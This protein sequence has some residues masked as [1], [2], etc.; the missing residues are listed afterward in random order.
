MSKFL[1]YLLF[2]VIGT[3][4]A[5]VLSFNY[6]EVFF[7]PFGYLTYGLLYIFFIEFLITKQ[8]KDWRVVYFLGILVGFI[9]E[10]YVPKVI[11]FGWDPA[12]SLQ[13]FGFA[14]FEFVVLSFFFHPLFSWMLP[15][16]IAQRYLKFPF[17]LPI[18]EKSN[19]A[20]WLSL[21]YPL[22]A[23][24]AG[25]YGADGWLLMLLVATAVIIILIAWFL[26]RRPPIADISL[27]KRTRWF[28]LGFTVLFYT[29][30]L[31]ASDTFNGEKM[32]PGL[33]QIIGS[34]LFVLLMEWLIR[35]QTR[36][37][38]KTAVAYDP[39]SANKITVPLTIYTSVI[40]AI[41]I[42]TTPIL[43]PILVISQTSLVVGG[44]IGFIIFLWVS[45]WVVKSN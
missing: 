41:V 27:G 5:E 1:F 28:L 12:T 32:V 2:I 37:L 31:F 22:L 42:L 29:F 39:Q 16:Y 20:L 9:T 45:F 8:V 43:A 33:P 35:R 11:F 25:N 19:K 44:V 17:N 10:A 24:A 40:I 21:L 18:N 26:R 14:P 7:S 4:C 30:T 13:V 3:A 36:G 38:E 15:V 34:L 23:F 6:V